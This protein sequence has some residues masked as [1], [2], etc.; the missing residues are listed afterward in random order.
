MTAPAQSPIKGAD[1][2]GD[3]LLG[4]IV[5]NYRQPDDLLLNI[6]DGSFFRSFVTGATPQESTSTQTVAVV[7]NAD[8]LVDILIDNGLEQFS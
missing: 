4:L 5:G 1:F 8:G 7:V 6:G 3:G 2:D